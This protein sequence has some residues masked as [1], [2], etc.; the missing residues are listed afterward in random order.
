M[1]RAA[2]GLGA[3]ATGGGILVP[4]MGLGP[5]GLSPGG[6]GPGGLGTP[7]PAGTGMRGAGPEP[8]GGLIRRCTCGGPMC[9]MS[10]LCGRTVAPG[11]APVR[12]V[13]ARMTGG[14]AMGSRGRTGAFTAG[15]ATE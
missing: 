13:G 2:P 8:G 14:G 6:L 1:G 11:G 9:R 3:G 12:G 4:F 15:L 7:L 10:G 5:S